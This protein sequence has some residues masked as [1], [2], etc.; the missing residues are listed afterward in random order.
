MEDSKEQMEKNVKKERTG[1]K[2][3]VITSAKI[4]VTME[5]EIKTRIKKFNK[6]KKQTPSKKNSKFKYIQI[7][8]QRIRHS[9]KTGTRT[10]LFKIK[11]TV[12][13]ERPASL[14]A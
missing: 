9:Q 5:T 8:S 3:S 13:F 10:H 4:K 12:E 14:P 6:H 7:Y 2:D 11:G 1:T